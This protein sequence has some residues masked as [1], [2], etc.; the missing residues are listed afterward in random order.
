MLAFVVVVPV[1]DAELA[2]DRLFGLGVAAVEERSGELDGHVELW[3][4][5]G[6]S[7][8]AIDGAVAALDD[9]WVWRTT[10]LDDSVA[11][12]W[13]QFAA[14]IAVGDDIVIVPAWLAGIVDAGNAT[15]ILID[16]GAAFGMGDH[17]TTQL[18]LRALLGELAHRP[19]PA[20]VLDVGCGSGVLAIAA[21]QRGA[22]PVV[23][24]DISVAAVEATLANA[25]TN[26]LADVVRASTTALAEVVAEFDIVVAN[27]L[28]PALIDL[29]PDLRR[30]VAPGGVLVV[31]GIL[32]DRYDNVL[33]ALAPLVP[34]AT[35]AD[36]GWVAVSL[37]AGGCCGC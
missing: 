10:E 12:T 3:T 23:G 17:P 14:P 2:A 11:D 28:A 31:S 24:I 20:S 6:D 1:A 32:A 22:N 15:P 18:T 21:A 37:S 9:A 13:R 35:V 33:A 5:V 34:V 26:G 8:D 36:Q 4:E 29:A 30:V 19:P 7:A 16:P 25:G 27:V